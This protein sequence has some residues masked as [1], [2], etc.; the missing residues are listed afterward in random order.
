MS[1]GNCSHPEAPPKPD[2]RPALEIL[3]NPELFAIPGVFLSLAQL[4]SPESPQAIGWVMIIIS[5]LMLS[6]NQGLGIVQYFRDPQKVQRMEDMERIR[7]ESKARKEDSDRR[8][9]AIEERVA[10]FA[11][12]AQLRELRE[13]VHNRLKEM[14]AYLH[15]TH[16]GITGELKALYLAGE[17]R[18]DTT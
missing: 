16:H 12:T 8:I 14:S 10:G 1:Q 6:V 13:D 17:Q 3:L 5:S 15:E 7:G 4:P 18:A 2:A 11:T 9:D